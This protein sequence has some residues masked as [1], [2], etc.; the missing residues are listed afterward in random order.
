MVNSEE[1][2]ASEVPVIH[3]TVPQMHVQFCDYPRRIIASHRIVYHIKEVY[4]L[5][6]PAVVAGAHPMPQG[7]TTKA[8]CNS[9]CLKQL[10]VL[11]MNASK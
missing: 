11:E 10:R 7:S 6:K 8:H 2:L 3:S 9:E 4:N 1:A 5:C